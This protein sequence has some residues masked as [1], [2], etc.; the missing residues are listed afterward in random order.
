MLLNATWVGNLGDGS[1][2]LAPGLTVSV[3]DEVQM[4]WVALLAWVS[5][6]MNSPPS[7][8]WTPTQGCPCKGMRSMQRL[9]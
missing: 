4:C 7:I 5:G 2:L 9:V 3:S 8:C 1:G 6:P